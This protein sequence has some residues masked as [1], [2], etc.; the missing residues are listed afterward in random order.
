MRTLV[1]KLKMLLSRSQICCCE[2]PVSQI[3]QEISNVVGTAVLEIQIIS[4]FPHIQSQQ[5][6]LAVCNRGVSVSSFGNFQS[7]VV[8]NQPSPPATKLSC[9]SSLEFFFE[10]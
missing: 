7:T 10:F 8:H 5:R 4:V 3:I 9:R 6:S 2:I 1:L